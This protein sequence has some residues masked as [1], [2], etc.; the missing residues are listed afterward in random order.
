MLKEDTY[1][2]I[3]TSAF[4]APEIHKHLTKSQ[5]QS[6]AWEYKNQQYKVAIEIDE[7]LVELGICS[8]ID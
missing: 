3:A 6:L 5:A 2:L 7:P 8:P 1:T 4:V